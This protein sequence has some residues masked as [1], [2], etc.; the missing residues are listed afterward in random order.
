[1]A[2]PVRIT[3]LGGLGRIGRNCAVLDSD[4]ALLLVDCGQMFADDTTPGVDAILPDFTML[5]E[6]A[7]DIAGVIATHGHEDH[8]GALGYLLRDD[9]FEGRRVPII[10]TAFTLGL[11]R[12]KLD[13][14]RVLSRAELVVVADNERRSFGPFDCEFLP[15]TH[16]TPSGVIS[17]IRTAQGAIVHSGDLKIDPAPVD[18]RL[19]D[20]SRLEDISQHEG[21]R[22]LLADSTN[23]DQPGRTRP[24]T[25]IG[26]V[27]RQVFEAHPDKRITVASFASHVHRVQQVADL[28]V[29][30]GRVVVPLGFSMVRN[31]KL[32][33]DL[34]LMSVPTAHL[35]EPDDAEKLDP[36][37][38]CVV[39][40]GSQGEPRSALWQ[41]VTG[42]SRWVTLGE[43]DVVV[44]SSHPI[45]GNEAAVAR[46]RNELTRLGVT[47]VHSGQLDVHTSGHA[48]QD[49][50]ADFHR[51]VRPEW[52]VPVHGE[53]THLAEHAALARRLGMPA[54][55]V[56]LC[57]DGDT[58]VV[59]DD[60][61]HVEAGGP[62]RR[63]YVDGTIGDVDDETL[64]E[65]TILGNGG[66]V[67]VFVRVDLA[68]RTVLA[69]PVVTSRGW[70]RDGIVGRLEDEVRAAV[71]E[72]VADV[73]EENG[74][75]AGLV[76]RAVRRAAGSTVGERTR[77]R[78]MIVP[79]VA[80]A[81][82]RG[83]PHHPRD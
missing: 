53:Y 79:V 32:A 38:V 37:E 6:R 47:V 68:S 73:L 81:G 23:A 45:P 34:G 55:N 39:C 54:G 46:L 26:Q 56:V 27:L 40:T 61:C 24:E 60:G 51:A 43:H 19:T 11:V 1:M 77:R 33:R 82:Q 5:R 48:K 63:V 18:D 80:V 72:A 41:M 12:H 71:I 9:A 21:I 76:E 36:A 25:A 62:Q 66:F 78:P 49:E 22:L 2:T 75:T 44:F 14:A 64:R 7:G 13:E 67:A 52:F 74:V 35:G 29:E 10:G 58:L 70:S 59:A 57:E 20:L 4:G 30:Y 17:V 15:V 69:P 31:S 42:E 65:R 16:S 3:F 50:L 28:A 83:E 8:I